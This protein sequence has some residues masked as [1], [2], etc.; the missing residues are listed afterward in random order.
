MRFNN[1]FTVSASWSPI[2]TFLAY[3]TE[4]AG[5][6][7]RYAIDVTFPDPS[8]NSHVITAQ[9]L[10]VTSN[11]SRIPI[12]TWSPDG[13]WIAFTRARLANYVVYRMRR[14]GNDL[15]PLYT[16]TVPISQITISPNGK[17]M[18]FLQ[19]AG[20]DLFTLYQINL[21][22]KTS[23]ILGDYRVPYKLLAWSPDSQWLTYVVQEPNA[24]VIYRMHPDG[25]H[26]EQLH[27]DP[28]PIYRLEWSSDGR[29]IYFATG[30]RE[31]APLYR[32]NA[33]GS[34][35][36]YLTDIAFDWD[37]PTSPVVDLSWHGW[38]PILSSIS[39]VGLALFKL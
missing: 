4:L 15:Q 38:L 5:D 32:I 20:D 26:I 27:R 34:N 22:E 33:D 13:E 6:D 18:N 28:N 7:D 37:I 16:N 31:Q 8:M 17:W 10:F 35:L 24:N 9:R 19:F 36:Q 29:W 23:Q 14:D 12:F 11:A 2:D 39:L 25:S 3:R 30:R 21:E 1:T